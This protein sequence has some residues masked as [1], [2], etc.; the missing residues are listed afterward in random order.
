[1]LMKN[2]CQE[3]TNIDIYLE[4]QVVRKD[5]KEKTEQNEIL[6]SSNTQLKE[7]LEKLKLILQNYTKKSEMKQKDKKSFENLEREHRQQVEE[8]KRGHEILVKKLEN[9]KKE[10]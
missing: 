4:W 10:R 6:A 9:E 7:E 1:M 8:A 5:Y 2:S 3:Q